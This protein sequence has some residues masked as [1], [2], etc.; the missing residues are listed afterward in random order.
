M[1]TFSTSINSNSTVIY[2]SD[3][4]SNGWKIAMGVPLL[5]GVLPGIFGNLLVIIAI[6][7]TRL[8]RD[9]I[10]I[11]V[12]NLAVTDILMCA[13]PLPILGVYFVF[14]WPQWM[15]GEGWC[16]ITIYV[17]NICA[18]VSI[19]IM[20]SIAVDRYFAVQRNKVFFSR[21]KCHVTI[22]LIWILSGA[23]AVSNVLKGGV[24]QERLQHGTY[25]VC[26]RITGKAI[27]D[28]SIKLSLIIKLVIGFPVIIGLIVIYIRL[29]Y[30]VWKQRFT[31]TAE[32]RRSKSV[33][34]QH[35]V[36][37]RAL[38]MMFAIVVAFGVCWIPYYIIT[39]IRVSDDKNIEPGFVLYSYVLA[40]LNS[41]VNPVLYAL[42]SKKFRNAFHN[43]LTGTKERR[44]Q[45]FRTSEF[46][47]R[48]MKTNT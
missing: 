28:S 19:L 38:K 13:F 17:V 9:I 44:I 4:I 14:Y 2:A 34:K 29:S 5:I 46:R 30:S 33:G 23:I 39:S 6:T 37:T 31:P 48:S 1:P 41:T 8:N 15:L 21:R 25:A 27:I 47:H 12:L 11:M 40:M 35:N 10:N 7:A 43:I 16:K 45:S 36:K 18:I 22:V 32:D 24:L 20:T 26:N 42:L 3:R